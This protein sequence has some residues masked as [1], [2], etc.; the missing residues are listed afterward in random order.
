MIY[1]GYEG[2]S[3]HSRTSSPGSVFHP[4]HSYVGSFDF[5]KTAIVVA[6]VV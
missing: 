2:S 5:D 1:F 3:N 4:R 6:V